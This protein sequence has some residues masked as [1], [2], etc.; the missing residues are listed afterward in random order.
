MTLLELLR[1][2]LPK[3]GGWPEG[4]V[5]VVQDEDD[6][7]FYFFIGSAP[8]FDGKSWWFNDDNVDNEWIYH[9]YKNPLASDHATAI[10]TR[11][12]YEATAWDGTNLPPVGVDVEFTIGTYDIETDFDGILPVEGEIVEVIAHKTTSDG[13]DVAVVYWDDKGAGRSACF[14]PGCLRP[15]RTEAERAIDEMVR[16][17]GVSIG[18]AKILYDAGYRK[19]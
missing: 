1:Q 12:Q 16:L 11:E 10:V 19:G 17:S 15:L 18:A 9:N 8:K 2:K 6:T 14:V 3:R 7:E 13:N 4:A 5:G